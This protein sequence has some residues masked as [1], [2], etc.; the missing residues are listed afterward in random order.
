MGFFDR[1]FGK[2]KTET[3]SRQLPSNLVCPEFGE[4]N[5]RKMSQGTEVLF[6]ILMEPEGAEAE[7]W[8]T[9]VA[10][11]GSI[12]MMSVFGRCLLDGPKGSVP[13]WLLQEYQEKGWIQV[14][15]VDGGERVFWSG[16]ASEDAIKRGYMRM[17]EN[18]VEP[19]AR[20]MTAYLAGNLD[21]D[22]GTTLIYW[23][24]GDGSSYEVVG[25]FTVDQCDEMSV[26]GPEKEG[27]GGGTHLTPAVRY[28][29]ERFNDAARGMYLFITDG[30][31]D[32]L[33]NVKRYTKELA[34]AIQSGKRNPVKC[35][36]IGVGDDIDEG[37]ME[38]LDDLDTGTDVDIWDH[39]ISKEMRSLVEIFAEVVSENK[40]VAPTAVIYDDQGQVAARFADGLP[41]KVKFNL[42]KNATAFE[43]EVGGR[44]IRQSITG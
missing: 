5:V 28:F 6:T 9:G 18:V 30:K 1:L 8:Q 25:D 31:L 7:G 34:R 35:V 2:S 41:A 19:L 23:A 26:G 33:A 36:L 11:D 17:T 13:R 39:K 20:K 24:C 16:Q 14:A 43:L 3:A 42:P 4:V 15:N 22:G 27:F 10:L 44:R 12:S 40:I 32:D 38:E 29:C 37:Q 21:A